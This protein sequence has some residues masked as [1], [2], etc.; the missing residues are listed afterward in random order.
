[1][2]GGGYHCYC[3]IENLKGWAG[4]T[5]NFLHGGGMDIFWNY[6]FEEKINSHNKREQS[7]YVL[8]LHCRDPKI[9]S[10]K[11]LTV[12]IETYQEEN[13]K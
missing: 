5:S 3:K 12:R 11:C 2:K 9:S 4:P 13:F 10:K 8:L 1:M 7:Q 6:P